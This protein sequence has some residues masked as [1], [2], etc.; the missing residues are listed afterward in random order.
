MSI[1]CTSQTQAKVSMQEMARLE[2]LTAN[3]AFMPLL[4]DY[5]K[6]LADPKA[7]CC[8]VSELSACIPV[9][10]CKYFTT[11]HSVRRPW[12]RGSNT[13]ASLRRIRQQAPATAR[14]A[15]RVYW[16]RQSPAL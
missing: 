6:D 9:A 15:G 4:E 11:V 7:L 1:K 14:P 5:A 16:Q 2:Q 3:S 8:C 10:A 13:S 12:K